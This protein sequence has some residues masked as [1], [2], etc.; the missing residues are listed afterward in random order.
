MAEPG[1]WRP[2]CNLRQR[3]RPV[4]RIDTTEEDISCYPYASTSKT[5]RIRVGQH[6]MYVVDMACDEAD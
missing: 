5:S 3:F 6:R 1:C 4:S 2:H